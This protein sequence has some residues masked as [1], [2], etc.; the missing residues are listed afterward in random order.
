MRPSGIAALYPR[1]GIRR[2]HSRSSGSKA[3]PSSSAKALRQYTTTI[4]YGFMAYRTAAKTA[5]FREKNSRA[6]RNIDAPENTTARKTYAPA[7]AFQGKR[8]PRL[9]PRVHENG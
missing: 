3:P 4:T 2:T 9:A 1:C 6:S 5:S 8:D 7:E